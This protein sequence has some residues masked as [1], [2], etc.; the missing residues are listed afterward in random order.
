MFKYILFDFDG[1]VYD[2]VEGITKS[3]QHAL[4]IQGIEEPMEA[5]RCFAGPPLVD[6]FMEVYGFDLEL[7]QQVTRDFK[8]RY[9]PIGIN[10][11]QLFPGIK[12]AL[13]R[14]KASGAKLG[15]ATSKPEHLALQLLE[16]EGMTELFDCICGSEPTGN[17][18]AK[19]QVLQRAM[20]QLGASKDNSILV[21][22][23]KYDVEGAKLCGIPCL[24]VAY[25]YAA[26]GELKAAG[27][28]D[29]VPDID[30]LLS[31][32]LSRLG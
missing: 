19:W 21:G 29:I 11:C 16:K 31:W 7:A 4:R 24:G 5:L 26:P 18:N 14:L 15:I 9:Q 28:L 27:A 30:S 23:T 2:T 20:E 1:T 6:K 32:L 8:A 3:V 25:G 10:E 12:E 22:D 13:A 17:N